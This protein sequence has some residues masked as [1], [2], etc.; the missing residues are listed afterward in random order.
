[1]NNSSV[2]PPLT[3]FINAKLDTILLTTY[4]I[5]SILKALNPNKAHGW[6]NISVKMIKICGEHIS[7]PLELIFNYCVQ[8]SCYPSRWKRG[9]IAPVHKKSDKND[10]KNYRPISLLPI[11][12]K[13]FEK[14]ILTKSILS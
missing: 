12:S 1:M 14:I 2:L 10:I 3:H 8:N 5:N 13:I 9:N 7:T 11:F 4:K 6:D